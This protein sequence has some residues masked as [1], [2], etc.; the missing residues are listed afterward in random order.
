M[1]SS[2]PLM[3]LIQIKTQRISPVSVTLAVLLFL[4]WI[5][6]HLAYSLGEEL[7]PL[8]VHIVIEVLS[9]I[10]AILVFLITWTTYDSTRVHHS[11][12]LAGGFLAVGLL[13][14]GHMLSFRGMPDFITPSGPEKAIQFWLA[15]R[16]VGALVLL[17]FA[18]RWFKPERTLRA[19]PIVLGS[20]LLVTALAYLSILSFGEYWP[21]TYIQ[22][23]G[24]TSFKIGAEYVVILIL[25]FAAVRIYR[26]P[27][28]DSAS[29]FNAGKLFTACVITILS[30]LCFVLYGSV[31][32]VFNLLG[33]AYKIIAYFYIYQ[34]VFVEGVR[35]PIIELERTT[36][37]LAT[38]RTIL[39]SILDNVPVRIFWKDKESRFIG[40]NRLLLKDLGLDDVHQIIGKSD[41]DFFSVEQSGKFQAD[42]REVMVSGM[43]K[44]GIEEPMNAVDGR[45]A[46]LLTNKAPLRGNE[47][48]IVGVLGAFVD[49]TA[50]R[51]VERKLEESH[52]QLLELTIWR[53]EAREGERKRIAQ[54]LHDDLGQMLTSLRMEVALMRIKYGA[55][56]NELAAKMDTLKEHIDATI[57]VVRDVSSQLRP[58]VLDT[59]ITS[60]LEW[61]VNQFEY[62]NDVACHLSIDEDLELSSEMSTTIFRIVQES[63]TNI[64]RHAKAKNVDI[65]LQ[66]E[67]ESYLLEIVDDGVGFD[68]TVTKRKSF[69][70]VGMRERALVLGAAFNVISA[71]G[72]GTTIS[73]RIPKPNKESK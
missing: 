51:E 13:D 10:V 46:W 71:V 47:G 64:M 60:A 16:F 5:N 30:E 59:G 18:Y 35:E 1:L 9:I 70:L 58:A 73:I 3:S 67:G 28:D 12:I 52:K 72:K 55:K 32:D 63:L 15:A 31:S 38:S 53:E 61:Q 48:E 62:R 2:I 44:L 8:S 50:Q 11:L 69:G 6:A 14:L 20:S 43:P 40:A 66:Q 17:V 65:K 4:A 37:E 24:L 19:K 25:L 36:Q 29:S 45:S 54:D 68:T 42:D 33:H 34:A 26:S 57:Q 7:M 21:R 27:V 49:I 56:D 23:I 39:R 41:N 22:G